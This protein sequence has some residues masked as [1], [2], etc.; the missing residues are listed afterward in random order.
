MRAQERVL[1]H[2]SN[3]GSVRPQQLHP[4]RQV[5][6]AHHNANPDP[7]TPWGRHPLCRSYRRILACTDVTPDVP[8]PWIRAGSAGLCIQEYALRAIYSSPGVYQT[9]LGSKRAKGIMVAAYLD[10]WLIWAKSP[11]E[12]KEAT[13]KVIDFL[14]HLGFLVNYKKSR[15]TPEQKFE[16]LGLEW[17]LS[18]HKL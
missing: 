8:L 7:S 15:L 1:Q 17:D 11:E 9:S 3:F 16:W 12:C 13:Q 4:L 6:D 2:E 10:D 18:T 14:T 5:Q